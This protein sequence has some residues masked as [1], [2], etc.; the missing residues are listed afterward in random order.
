MEGRHPFIAR[1]REVRKTLKQFEGRSLVVDPELRS[2]YYGTSVFRSVTGRNQP[3]NFV[4]GGPKWM[5]Y[6]IVPESPDHVLVYAD[7]VAQ[8]IGIAAALSGDPAMRAVYEACDCHMEFAVRAGAAPA[9]ATKRS[10]PE[11]RKRYKTVNLG[12]LYGQTAHGIATRLGVRYRDAEAIVADHQALFRDFWRWSGRIVQ[13]AYDLGNIRT[14]CG[15]RSR[16]P[17]GSNERTWMNWPMQAAGGDIMRLTITYLDRQNVRVLAPVHDGFLLSCRREQVS[18]LR[19]ALDFACGTAAD[20]VLPGF[21]L[22]WD[23]AVYEN[24][25]FEDEDGLPLWQTLQTIVGA[26]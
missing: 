23:V 14:P 8:E 18:D 3:T 15:W 21:P 6:L 20:Q 17:P 19:A 10:H 5:R 1:V 7:F 22:R 12:S 16:V 4:F 24:G 13:A 26:P 11:I 2:H 25:R 9:G